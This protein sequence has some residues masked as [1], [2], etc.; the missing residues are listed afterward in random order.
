MQ[1]EVR[2]TAGG[3]RLPCRPCDLWRESVYL[4]KIRGRLSHRHNRKAHIGGDAERV[5]LHVRIEECELAPGGR[6]VPTG[7]D[8]LHEEGRA[9]PVNSEED[10]AVPVGHPTVTAADEAAP[11]R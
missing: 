1:P 2:Q 7:D 11:R 10:D 8:V 4:E 3:S 6:R 9:R 5:E